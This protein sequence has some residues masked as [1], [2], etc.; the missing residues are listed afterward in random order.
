MPHIF[1]SYSH[2]DGD[3]AHRLAKE[4]EQQGFLAWIDERNGLA[5]SKSMWTNVALSLSL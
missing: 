5:S 4:L 1:I 2:E 3:Y